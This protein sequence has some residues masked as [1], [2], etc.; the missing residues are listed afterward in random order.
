MKPQLTK[1]YCLMPRGSRKLPSVISRIYLREPKDDYKTDILT[2]KILHEVRMAEEVKDDENLTPDDFSNLLKQLNKN[3]KMKYK[4]TLKSGLSYQKCLFKLFKM[5]WESE[6]KP[7]Q[8]EQTVAHQ[9]YKGAGVKSSLSNYRFIHTKNE[10]PKAFEH[11]LVS[12]SKPK[13]VNG[14]TRF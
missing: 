1:K 5:V 12:K 14:C 8:W 4:F 9:L 3:N 2:L 10:N 6:K 7:V 11:I 13:I